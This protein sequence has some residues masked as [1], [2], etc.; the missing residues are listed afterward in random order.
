MVLPFAVSVRV[1]CE[2]RAAPAWDSPFSY[3]A[4]ALTRLRCGPPPSTARL[5]IWSDRFG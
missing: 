1:V 5:R 2:R 4:A 3:R